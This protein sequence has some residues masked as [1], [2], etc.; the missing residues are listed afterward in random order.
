MG[1]LSTEFNVPLP[2]GHIN[3]IVV[4]RPQ[5]LFPSGIT[6]DKTRKVTLSL[7]VLELDVLQP[8]IQKTLDIIRP[9]IEIFL[10]SPELPEWVPPSTNL[11]VSE[12]L[13]NLRIPAY[14]NGSPSLLF[15]NLS[16]QLQGPNE[17]FD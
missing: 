8:E 16:S 14:Q 1:S 9:E 12:F 13:R 17:I 4:K 3:I 15:H 7:E 11:N 6:R 10:R 5:R 2:D